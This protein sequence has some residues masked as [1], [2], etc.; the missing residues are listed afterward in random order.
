MAANDNTKTA[1]YEN[2]PN[3]PLARS[4]KP[5]SIAT[6]ASQTIPVD[7][8]SYDE[9]GIEAK[10]TGTAAG[11]LAVSVFPVMSDGTVSAVALNP[12]SST[13]PTVSAPNV[14]YYAN[15][16]I[17]SHTRVVIS[18]KNNNAAT[19]TGTIDYQLA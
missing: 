9:M 8:G 6:G 3:A 12:I 2:Y 17:S 7:A 4:S 16:D 10:M 13:G 1:A 19:Q 15:Y 18:V 5:L 11:D 14:Y